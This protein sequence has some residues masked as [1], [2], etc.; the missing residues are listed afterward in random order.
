MEE[1]TQW[2]SV[3]QSM[4]EIA[5]RM[6]K[7]GLHNL[8]FF[9]ALSGIIAIKAF[10]WGGRDRRQRTD[11]AG[12]RTAGNWAQNVRTRAQTR[13]P[14][15]TDQWSKLCVLVQADETFAKMNAS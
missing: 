14:S 8:L 9:P 15:P 11:Q 5:E 2:K 12:W 13:F 3:L 6:G 10:W 1:F 7:M 4:E